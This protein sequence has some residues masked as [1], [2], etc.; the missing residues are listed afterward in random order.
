M[1]F[2]RCHALGHSGFDPFQALLRELDLGGRDVL[3][4]VLDPLGPGDRN[5][6]RTA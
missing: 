6:V 2:A 5:D 1:A 4:E 3:L